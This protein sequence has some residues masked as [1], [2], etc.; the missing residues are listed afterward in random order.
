MRQTEHTH[1]VNLPNIKE[2]YVKN[3]SLRHLMLFGDI[4]LLL[5]S[6]ESNHIFPYILEEN[7]PIK[8]RFKNSGNS[9][10]RTKVSPHM[11]KH[12]NLEGH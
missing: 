3:S 11:L 5:A 12:G 6:I 2:L 9:L 8:A 10:L 7:G 4:P 1:E